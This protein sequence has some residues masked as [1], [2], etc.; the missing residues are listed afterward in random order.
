MG[1]ILHSPEVALP[2]EQP[3]SLSEILG[4]QIESMRDSIAVLARQKDLISDSGGDLSMQFFAEVTGL[5]LTPL[6]FTPESQYPYQCWDY[7]SRNNENLVVDVKHINAGQPIYF[8]AFTIR[9]REQWSSEK[10]IM[11]I[12][13]F[14]FSVEKPPGENLKY[15]GQE[16]RSRMQAMTRLVIDPTAAEFTEFTDPTVPG[17]TLD[18]CVQAAYRRLLF[19]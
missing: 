18:V 10:I 15:L 8:E 5:S 4:P 7:D 11:E 2:S 19:T 9:P 1:E 3:P 13:D 12:N 17:L 14:R 6:T 16:E